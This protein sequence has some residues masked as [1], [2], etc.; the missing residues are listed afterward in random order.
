VLLDARAF[1][2]STTGTSG[3]DTWLGA[4]PSAVDGQ[5]KTS[6]VFLK[7][8]AAGSPPRVVVPGIRYVPQSNANAV[9]NSGDFLNGSDELAGRRLMV[10]HTGTGYNQSASGAYLMDITGPWR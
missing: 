8:Q 7:Q 9:L 3:N 5:V 6:R 10:L 1:A 2:G 4:L